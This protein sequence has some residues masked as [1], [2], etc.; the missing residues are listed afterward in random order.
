[1]FDSNYT[2]SLLSRQRLQPIQDQLDYALA[3]NL[4]RFDILPEFPFLGMVV[5]RGPGID[6]VPVFNHPLLLADG[7]II[8]D[9]RPYHNSLNI[10][11]EITI[12]ENS[13][14]MMQVKLAIYQWL[15]LED[16]QSRTA[17]YRSLNQLPIRTFVNWLADNLVRK[18][19]VDPETQFKVRT[20]VAWYYRCLFV[21]ED[22]LQM[23]EESLYR[24]ASAI[25]QITWLNVE[26]IVPLIQ[27]CGYIADLDG[28]VEQLKKLGSRRIDSL[29]TGTIY[30]VMNN[31]WFG[32]AS[33][34]ELVAAALEYPP[35]FIALVEAAL[36]ER[37][38]RKAGIT[39][40]LERVKNYRQEGQ[41]LLRLLQSMVS[42]AKG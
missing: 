41:Q 1:M 24:H 20:I 19:G 23:D 39:Q 40:A 10:A 14:A 27:E 25:S 36:T 5:G 22:E 17:F 21:A 30:A 2:T 35:T 3:D 15:W 32:S 26:A 12:P 31:T 8:I 33:A 28:L 9:L 38:Y 7:R 37:R 16:P 34:P 11:G 4:V 13:P 6:K 42:H 29:T 18:L